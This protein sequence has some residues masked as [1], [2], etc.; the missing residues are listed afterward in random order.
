VA[1]GYRKES[2]IV[3]KILCFVIGFLILMSNISFAL[4]YSSPIITSSD[5]SLGIVKVSLPKDT[6][7]RIKI[8]I[9]KDQNRYIYNY[10]K[11]K[12]EESFPLQM[13]NG[14]Y[15]VTVLENTVENKYK[16]ILTEKFETNIEEPNKVFLQSVQ[17]IEWDNSLKAVEKAKELTKDFKTDRQKITAIYTYITT[18]IKYDYEKIKNLDTTYLPDIDKIYEDG[19]GICY[20]FSAVMAGML[21]SIGIPSKLVK[22]YTDNVT[23]YH[24][25]NE[26]YI[27]GS[28]VVID[29]S[30][31]SQLISLGKTVSMVKDS[32]SYN[33]IYEY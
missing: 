29:T 18:N 22:G 33:K 11:T 12:Q 4:D 1:A 30:Y 14:Q 32:S 20:D 16:P 6:G 7:K 24:A 17:S 27:D 10:D 31:D 13:G 26:V 28:W 23:S 25:W 5:I 21:R 3:K 9:E 19:K 8:M 15:K 2:I